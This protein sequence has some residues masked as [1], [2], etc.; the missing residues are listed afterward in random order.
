MAVKERNQQLRL[1]SEALLVHI[2][3]LLVKD[4]GLAQDLM[5]VT[6]TALRTIHEDIERSSKAWDKK[7]YHVRADE[8]RREWGWTEGAANYALGLALRSRPLKR[9]DVAKLRLLIKVKL[10]KPARRQMPDPT[11]F[12]GAAQAVRKIESERKRPIRW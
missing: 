3:D 4:P 9:T 5:S 10:E 8:L 1:I 11:R 2:P 12:R 7:A 6:A